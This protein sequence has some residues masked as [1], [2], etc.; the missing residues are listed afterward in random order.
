MK[1][2]DAPEELCLEV[3]KRLDKAGVLQDIILVGSWCVYFYKDHFPEMGLLSR[4]R[5]RDMDFLIPTPLK[6]R[7]TI[8]MADILKDL[9]F[10]MD[11]Q[12]EGHVRLTHPELIIDFLV[13]EKGRGWNGPYPIKALGIT[14]QPLRFLNLLL[15]N[16]I[17]LKSH[18]ILLKLPHPINYAF[19]K[20]IISNRRKNLEKKAKDR[21]Q[22]IEV[23]RA[24]IEKGEGVRV[25]QTFQKFPPK[26]RKSIL[27]SLKAMDAQELSE[28][29]S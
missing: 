12:G 2:K 13:A 1:E 3:L 14:A 22:A 8:N 27:D 10:I 29:L 5:T 28:L 24:I 6:I 25:K 19:Q 15:D 23:L 7:T 4:I 11:F 21:I 9:G 17:T 20:L 26:W 16:P 18:G